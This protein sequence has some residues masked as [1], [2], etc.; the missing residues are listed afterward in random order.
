MGKKCIVGST[1]GVLQRQPLRMPFIW[2]SRWCRKVSL[3]LLLHC[4]DIWKRFH[5]NYFDNANRVHLIGGRQSS[6]SA[7]LTK[8]TAAIYWSTFNA[9]RSFRFIFNS[10]ILWAWSS[11]SV[12]FVR[13]FASHNHTLNANIYTGVWRSVFFCWRKLNENIKC[14]AKY[15]GTHLVDSVDCELWNWSAARVHRHKC[16]KV[17]VDKWFLGC[18]HHIVSSGDIA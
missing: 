2:R 4:G 11:G 8:L 3:A 9:F 13:S 16:K 15:T 5:Y 7:A 6:V 12:P 17:A 18:F 14:D 10:F 1:D